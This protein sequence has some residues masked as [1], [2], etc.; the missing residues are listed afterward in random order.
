M[1]K[2]SSSPCMVAKRSDQP[3]CTDVGFGATT[4][5]AYKPIWERPKK[6][7]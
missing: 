7:P 2:T 4:G 6:I 3:P 1:A 5:A